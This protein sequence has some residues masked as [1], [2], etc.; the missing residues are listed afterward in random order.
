[1]IKESIR[2]ARLL[3]D[4]QVKAKKTEIKNSIISKATITVTESFAELNGTYN[5][6]ISC[7]DIGSAITTA[8]KGK[9]NLDRIQDAVDGVVAEF[10]IKRENIDKTLSANLE[11]LKQNAQYRF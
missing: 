4:K 5:T 10:N 9:S 8:I 11:L 6:Q 3:T 7:S 1:E 2:Q